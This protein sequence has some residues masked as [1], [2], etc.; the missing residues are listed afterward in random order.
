MKLFPKKEE[1][2]TDKAGAEAYKAE[3]DKQIAELEAEAE[4]LTGKDN[5]KA[6]SAKGKEAMELRQK[7]KYIDACKVVKG[8]EPPHQ[9]WIVASGKESEGSK[10]APKEE[11]KAEQPGAKA[12]PK[13][14]EKKEAKKK[15]ESAGISPAERDELEKL[16]TDIIARKAELKASGMS[17]GQQNKDEQVVAWVTRM[18]E[19]KEKAEPGSTAKD[20]KKDDKKKSKGALSSTE[21]KEADALR[22]DIEEYKHKLTAEFGYAKKD[23]KNDPD[24]VEMES[25]LAALEKRGA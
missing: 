8:V 2:Q 20:A 15:V 1:V 16:K 24:L 14:D 3:I 5:K 12:E 6:R 4:A 18:N 17:G 21:Q 23:I 22:K 9:F 7:D 25:K 13:K 19:L 10:E 11:V